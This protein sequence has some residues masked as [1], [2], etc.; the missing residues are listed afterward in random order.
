ML[1]KSSNLA[2]LTQEARNP[3]GVST[4]P[5][6]KA[7]IATIILSVGFS[8]SQALALSPEELAKAKIL[9]SQ[10]TPAIDVSALLTEADKWG[11]ECD[12]SKKLRISVCKEDIETAKIEAEIEESKARTAL[13]RLETEALRQET[14]ANYIEIDRLKAEGERLDQENAE[15]VIELQRIIEEKNK[16]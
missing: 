11:V 5:P 13:L 1:Q 2:I 4:M 3:K 14:E 6:T 10:M 12:V 8:A 7:L 15:L 16:N 9:G